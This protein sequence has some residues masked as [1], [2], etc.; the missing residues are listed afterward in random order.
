MKQVKFGLTMILL[1]LFLTACQTGEP[2]T[3][4]DEQLEE[5]LR[6]EIGKE[7]EDLFEEDFEEMEELDLS[8]RSISDISDIGIVHNLQ[9]LSLENNEVTDISPLQDLEN[10]DEVNVE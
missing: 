1:M 2:V 6:Q 3:I 5:A 9:I 7:E 4:G 8:D 10:L